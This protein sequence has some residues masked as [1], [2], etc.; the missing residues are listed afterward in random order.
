M[1]AMQLFT[2]QNQLGV[3]S[4]FASVLNDMLKPFTTDDDVSFGTRWSTEYT[5]PHA[6]VDIRETSDAYV[7]ECDLP[8]VER[9]DI[10][11]Q[12]EDGV[13]SIK[14]SRNAG[15]DDAK[16]G[17][18]YSER[19][20]GSYERVF[21]LPKSVDASKATA[22]YQDGVLALH[23]PKHEEAKPKSIQVRVQER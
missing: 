6:P 11:I 13:V 7:I 3:P 23:V 21:R 17:F 20:F 2:K 19:R 4:P 22:S 1:T 16:D 9:S 8:G 18:R 12:V 15:K 5:T 10:G 14:A